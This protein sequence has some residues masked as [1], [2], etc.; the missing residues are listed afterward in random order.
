MLPFARAV[1]NGGHEVRVAAPASYASTVRDA[2]FAHEPFGDAPRER[3]G[4]VM[5]SLP[6]LEFAEADELVIR[7]VFGRIDAQAA[8][9]SLLET[10]ERWRPDLVLRESAEIASL[11]AA[12]RAGLPHVHVCIGM[13]E[14]LPRFAAAIS[15]PL[16]EL[17][18]VAGLAEGRASSALASET[19]LTSVPEI[20][21]HPHRP[22]A[23]R[24]DG[25]LRFHAPPTVSGAQRLPDWGDPDAPLVYA[26]FGSVAGS[27]APFAGVF[28]IALDAL[29]DVEARV[30]LTVGRKVDPAGL[31]PLP[32]NAH[33][34]QWW[35]QDAV[36]REASAMIAHGGFGT[37]MGALAA[38]VPQVVVPLFTFDQVVNGDHVAAV[39][40]GLTVAPGLSSMERAV[41]EVPRVLADPAYAASA[42]RIAAAMADLPSPAEAVPILAGLVG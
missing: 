3:V 13:H 35:P 7:E 8:L 40:A 18:Q 39:G 29:A 30:L 28:R 34:E 32:S 38:G 22:V 11:V 2:G 42:R 33:V 31:G 25:L 27:L 41:A 16:D 1:A 6:T 19:V 10:I 5:R 15:D 26:T 17:G 4:R 21:D 9:P 20:L 23:S 37:T 14:I 24:G 36:L 12:E